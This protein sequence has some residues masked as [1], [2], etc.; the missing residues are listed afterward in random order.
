MA[1][2]VST[3]MGTIGLSPGRPK[4]GPA[5]GVCKIA[6]A[7]S[8]LPGTWTMLQNILLGAYSH[9]GPILFTMAN[10][11]L[12][13]PKSYLHQHQEGKETPLPLFTDNAINT[14]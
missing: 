6:L 13:G 10:C 2:L 5:D 12:A 7:S 11:S 8:L 4:L 14:V 3:G 1:S 9:F